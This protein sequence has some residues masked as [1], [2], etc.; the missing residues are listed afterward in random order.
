MIFG[1]KQINDNDF[2]RIS[3]TRLLNIID[4]E[5]TEIGDGT[6]SAP[7]EEEKN[8]LTL[9]KSTAPE[10]EKLRKKLSVCAIA[11]IIEYNKD[12]VTFSYGGINYTI[13]K[14]NNSLRIARC[15]EYSIMSAL[16]ELNNQRCITVGAVPIA[17]DFSDVDADV[18]QLMSQISENFFFT[19]YL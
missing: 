16:E 19:P 14:P 7:T 1:N 9:L 10:A 8:W 5:S 2:P 15:R 18:I 3:R 12:R 4:S 6:T 17:K 13:N 11:E